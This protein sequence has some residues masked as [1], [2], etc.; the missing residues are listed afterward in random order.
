MI[1]IGQVPRIKKIADGQHFGIVA[2]QEKDV[3]GVRQ[4]IPKTPY[5]LFG[6]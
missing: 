5:A 4:F 2:A 1:M 6:F 3:I